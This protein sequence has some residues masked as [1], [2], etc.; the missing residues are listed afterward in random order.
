MAFP[1]LPH[2]RS[3][4]IIARSPRVIVPSKAP[5]PPPVP[6][7]RR[8][9]VASPAVLHTPPRRR[10]PGGR[11]APRQ[12]RPSHGEGRAAGPPALRRMGRATAGRCGAVWEQNDGLRCLR[13][14][15]DLDRKEQNEGR[16]GFFRDSS[17]KN[18]WI[19]LSLDILWS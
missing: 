14:K 6:H 10:L 3:K 17:M 16:S 19:V 7:G 4:G 5:P 9:R 12:P 15:D 2:L 8:P 11:A 1:A 18:T 13:S